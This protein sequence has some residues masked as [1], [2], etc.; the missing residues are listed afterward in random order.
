MAKIY[1]IES[2]TD[3]FIAYK[4]GKTSRK[5]KKRLKEIATGNAGKLSVIFEFESQNVNELEKTLHRQFKQ[6]HHRG[7]WFNDELNISKFIDACNIYEKAIKSI[8]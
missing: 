5:V 3:G 2:N 4:I 7:E 1:L 8:K 6:Y